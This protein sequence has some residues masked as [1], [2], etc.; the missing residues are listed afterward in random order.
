MMLVTTLPWLGVL[1]TI[2]YYVDF[3]DEMG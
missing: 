1:L 3:V 2:A